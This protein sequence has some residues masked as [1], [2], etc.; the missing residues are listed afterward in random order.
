MFNVDSAVAL[1]LAAG[2]PF[3]G[4]SWKN[5]PATNNGL[6]QPAN[7]VPYGSWDDTGM[8]DYKDIVGLLA[9]SRQFISG[10]GTPPPK[11]PSSTHPR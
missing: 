8:F 3:Y 1:Y 10:S 9:G 5:V 11:H 6:H 7:G 4:R 2:V